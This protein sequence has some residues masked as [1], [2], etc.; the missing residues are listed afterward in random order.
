MQSEA[1]NL[2]LYFSKVDYEVLFVYRLFGAQ[3]TSQWHAAAQVHYC[4]LLA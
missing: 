3:A 2:V 1:R 4:I